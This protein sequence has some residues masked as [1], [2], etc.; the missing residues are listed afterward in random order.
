MR[1]T[2]LDPRTLETRL[3]ERAKGSDF[4]TYADIQAVVDWSYNQARSHINPA[5]DP[6]PHSKPHRF[7]IQHVAQVI[8]E[9]RAS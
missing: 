4:C 8:A 3:R 5:L 9:G 2:S 7:L 6:I 1:K